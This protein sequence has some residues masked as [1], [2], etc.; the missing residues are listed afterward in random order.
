MPRDVTVMDLSTRG[1]SGLDVFP[2]LRAE[3]V[4]SKVIVLTMHN[5][6]NWRQIAMCEGAS[7]FLLKEWV[8]PA[9]S[10]NNRSRGRLCSTPLL[11]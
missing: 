2:R 1:L 3:R 9:R 11:S 7:G 8:N 10:H 4:D 6:P 5:D